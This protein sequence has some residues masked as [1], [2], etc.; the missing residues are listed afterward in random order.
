MDVSIINKIKYSKFLYNIY[1]YV[2]S[3][4]LNVLKW[5]VRPKKNLIVINSFGGRKFD[6]S[7]KSIYD[8][9]IKDHRFQNCEIVW[10]FIEPEKYT[11]PYGR[12]IKSD[13]IK[14]FI[15]L[16]KA[17]VWISNSALERGLRFKGRHTFYL[18]TWHGIPIKK[19]GSD[20]DSMNKSFIGKNGHKTIDVMLAQGEFDTEVF[21]RVF[22]I[23]RE[24]F[25]I[26]GL[27]RNDE[28]VRSANTQKKIEIKSKLGI[29]FN[30]KV[31]LYAPTFR[32]YQK[33]SNNNCMLVPPMNLVK[34]R[35]DLGEKYVLLF[36]AHYEVVK[37]MNLQNND[38]V[39]DVSKY[40]NLNDLMIVSDMLISDYSS[41]FFDYSIQRKPMFA[42]CYDY[43][44]YGAMRGLYFDIRKALDSMNFGVEDTLIEEISSE[45]W[46][47]RATISER[48]KNQYIQECGVAVKKTL[49]IIYNNCLKDDEHLSF[50]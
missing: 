12:K 23:P 7:P 10:A 24:K 2:G 26:I 47:Q 22:K 32:E 33:D 43:E 14:Y 15:T 9:M 35:K 25:A 11:I 5:I 20:I 21:S 6:D 18:N 41:I 37:I 4:T 46:T 40:D 42:F 45:R 39:K 49:D 17:R 29:P 28:L 27:P 16:L 1:F 38:F 13:T 30:K 36:R 3:I 50:N 8:E 44:K 19:M 48:F 31:I 34:W